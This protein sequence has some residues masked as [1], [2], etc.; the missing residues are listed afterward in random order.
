[1]L[2]TSKPRLS[3]A[4]VPL[5]DLPS[6]HRFALRSV[7]SPR[8]DVPRAAASDDNSTHWILRRATKR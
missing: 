8:E 1:M 6:D 3:D 7:A 5:D 4:L 2:I